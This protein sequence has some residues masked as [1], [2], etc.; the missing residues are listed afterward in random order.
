MNPGAIS[1]G[2]VSL[3][4]SSAA[5]L[6]SDASIAEH[7]TC[8]G[9]LRAEQRKIAE[10]IARAEMKY[11]EYLAGKVQMLA[12]SGKIRLEDRIRVAS[13][14]EGNVR[15]SIVLTEPGYLLEIRESSEPR[16]RQI[17]SYKF[18]RRSGDRMLEGRYIAESIESVLGIREN[19]YKG[20][21]VLA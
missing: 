20:E 15:G 5:E 19:L 12:A 1:T 18:K 21:Q 13:Y 11:A 6:F 3:D 9:E 8:I 10:R 2:Y 14:T 7:R 16:T 17:R 4:F